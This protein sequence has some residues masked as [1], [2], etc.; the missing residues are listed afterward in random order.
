[1]TQARHSH[2]QI[3]VIRRYKALQHYLKEQA[4]NRLEVLK[5]FLTV[6][7]FQMGVYAMKLPIHSPPEK[8]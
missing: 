1:M 7:S 6:S 3:F 2:T 5:F 8:F 4:L